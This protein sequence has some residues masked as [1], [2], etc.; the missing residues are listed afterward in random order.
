MGGG[1]ISLPFVRIGASRSKLLLLVKCVRMYFCEANRIQWVEAQA[2]HRSCADS[3]AMQFTA[4]GYMGG[5]P[6]II[7]NMSGS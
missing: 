3:K 4:V 7:L 5:I 6:V 2:R 1:A